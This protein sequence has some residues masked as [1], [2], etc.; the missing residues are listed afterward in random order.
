MNKKKVA[1]QGF[2]VPF[3]LEKGATRTFLLV[4]D[5]SY[6]CYGGKRECVICQVSRDGGG[7]AV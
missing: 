2:M 3:K 1:V 4:K 5:Q 6:C 7:K